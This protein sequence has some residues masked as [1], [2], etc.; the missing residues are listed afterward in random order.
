MSPSFIIRK[1]FLIIIY[2]YNCESKFL[3]P[4]ITEHSNL[5]YYLFIFVPSSHFKKVI[6]KNPI[7]A[8]NFNIMF[9]SFFKYYD[10]ILFKQTCPTW[11]ALQLANNEVWHYSHDCK[12]TILS[13][14]GSSNTHTYFMM[15]IHL[16]AITMPM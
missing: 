10:Y 3:P 15:H 9:I 14:F 11:G 8:C 7:F 5:I 6:R 13:H 2:F 1:S 16:T 4:G 12:H